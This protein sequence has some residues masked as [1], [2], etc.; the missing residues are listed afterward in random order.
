[1]PPQMAVGELPPPCS[2]L[3]NALN[4]MEGSEESL[5]G[6]RSS[7]LH[8][9]SLAQSAFQSYHSSIPPPYMQIDNKRI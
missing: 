8:D 1:M 6:L 4:Q 3:K 5:E 2:T 7:P 9:G